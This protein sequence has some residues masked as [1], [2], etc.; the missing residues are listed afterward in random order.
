MISWDFKKVFKMRGIEKPVPWLRA[1][2]VSRRLASKIAHNNCD[3]LSLY[4]LEL[5]CEGL[6][7]TPHDF[8]VWKPRRAQAEDAHHALRILLPD[9]S[10]TRAAGL[11]KKFT[12]EEI[13]ELESLMRKRLDSDEDEK[14]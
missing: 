9:K 12:L 2:G 6:K 3:K 1:L 10:G 13:R 11:L 7:C 5:L 14:D 8:M 4:H